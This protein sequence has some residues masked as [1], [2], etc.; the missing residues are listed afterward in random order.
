MS[1]LMEGD[2]NSS[3][4]HASIKTRRTNNKMKLDLADGSSTD[5]PGVIGNKAVDYFR[6]LFGAFPPK[7]ESGRNFTQPLVS[8]E[9]NVELVKTPDEN[10]VKDA[11][12]GMNPTGSPGPDGFTGKF[13]R[14]CWH[15]IKDDL[16]EAVKGYF[17]GLQVPNLISSAQIILL[18][19]VK[20]AVSLDKSNSKAGDGLQKGTTV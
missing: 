17:R 4:F 11:V 6:D 1:W 18:P 10:E 3:F 19:K 7:H 9:M 14:S 16:M 20:N 8:E 13:Y 12:F 2:R 15:I 5:D